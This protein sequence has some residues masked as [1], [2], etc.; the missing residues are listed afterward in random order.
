[1]VAKLRKEY[2]EKIIDSLYKSLNCKNIHQVL[3]PLKTSVPPLIDLLHAQG[4]PDF[5][6]FGH[7]LSIVI[8]YSYQ[9]KR[10][11]FESFR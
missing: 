6:Y 4:F 10:N 7:R 11:Y 2:K 1:M 5:S 9:R 3:V 8:L